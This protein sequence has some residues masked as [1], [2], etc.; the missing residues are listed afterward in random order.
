MTILI[1]Q[2]LQSSH[3]DFVQPGRVFYNAFFYSFLVL[4][5][6]ICELCL[7]LS[8]LGLNPF[9]HYFCRFKKLEKYVSNDNCN[10]FVKHFES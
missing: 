6:V 4:Y 10:G 3:C 5:C 8:I 7:V 2:D 9:V 1:S